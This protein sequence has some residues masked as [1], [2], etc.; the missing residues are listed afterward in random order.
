VS[1][2]SDWT[3]RLAVA[4]PLLLDPNFARSVV[5]LLQADP[6]DGALGLVLNRPSGTDV[7]DVLEPWKELAGSPPVVF[8]GGPVQPNAAICLG[9]GRAG[10]PAVAAYS[11]LENAPTLGTVDLDASPAD[12]SNTVRQVRVFAG[13][14]GWSA[15]QLEA[16]VDEGAW[17]ILDALPSD[18]FTPR[19]EL[20]W[21]QVL[22][23]QGP[24]IAFAAL[25][26]ED[27]SHN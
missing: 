19:P 23:R 13:Y 25:Y 5:L 21:S 2:S 6:D 3:G 22:R 16:E 8:S 18:A 26:P 27:P 14:A 9:R 17:W 7:E 11:Q 15:G 20:L 4:T 24:P 1:S 10:A 12:L